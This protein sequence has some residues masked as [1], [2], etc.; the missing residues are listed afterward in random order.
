LVCDERRTYGLDCVHLGS[1]RRLICCVCRVQL[2]LGHAEV[3]QGVFHWAWRE[4]AEILILGCRPL[5]G[6]RE[7]LVLGA[8]AWGLVSDQRKTLEHWPRVL[9]GAG[10]WLEIVLEILD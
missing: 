2:G 9:I 8:W 3:W 1:Q 4:I 7:N 10:H 6:F 5:V